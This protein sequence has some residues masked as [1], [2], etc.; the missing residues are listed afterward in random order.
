MDA[1]HCPLVLEWPR[2]GDVAAESGAEFPLDECRRR[3]RGAASGPSGNI[4][5]ERLELAVAKKRTPKPSERQVAAWL[6]MVAEPAINGL[7]RERYYLSVQKNS[8]WRFT[9]GRCQYARSVEE[10]VEVSQNP[11]LR[12]FLRFNQKVAK[13]VSAHDEALK[14]F[15]AAATRAHKGLVALDGFRALTAEINNLFPDWR[16]ALPADGGVNLLGEMVINWASLVEPPAQYTN[17]AAWKQYR[18]QALRF[19]EK[20]VVADLFKAADTNF[21]ELAHGCEKL[22]DSLERLRD[23]LADEY[24]LPPAAPAPSEV[25]RL[26]VPER[27]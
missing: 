18:T 21:M 16:G 6:Y 17:A 2:H 3:C 11:T 15:E 19:R 13:L 12:Q 23:G 1:R 4:A 7:S 22:V 27:F 9:T 26:N 14:T 8:G 10:L 20:P 5:P 24:G 25:V